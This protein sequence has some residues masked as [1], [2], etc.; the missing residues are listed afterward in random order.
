M[1]IVFVRILCVYLQVCIGY[2][3]IKVFGKD[4]ERPVPPAGVEPAAPGLGRRQSSIFADRLLVTV[5]AKNV[6]VVRFARILYFM[7]FIGF[8][9]FLDIFCCNFATFLLQSIE[10]VRHNKNCKLCRVGIIIIT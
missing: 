8:S 2:H 4:R 10:S 6:E 3:R 5:W 7:F 9:D 1:Y